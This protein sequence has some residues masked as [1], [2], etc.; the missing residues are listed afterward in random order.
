MAQLFVRTHGLEIL[1]EP[2]SVDCF[3]ARIERV[4]SAGPFVKVDLV[5]EWGAPLQV[6]ITHERYSTINLHMGMEV[7]ILPRE[8]CSFPA[9]EVPS[10]VGT[11][12]A[13]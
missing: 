8:V 5:S 12:V 3:R 1:L 10:A 4:N 9:K 2:N 11:S 7:Y 13:D 6:N